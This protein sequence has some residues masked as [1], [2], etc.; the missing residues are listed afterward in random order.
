MG[1]MATVITEQ[2]CNGSLNTSFTPS[3]NYDNGDLLF[4]YAFRRSTTAP[5]VGAGWTSVT[6]ASSGASS[7]RLGVKSAT[8]SS[9]AS[10]TWTNASTLLFAAFRSV[11]P[12]NF[13]ILAEQTGTSTTAQAG[14]G[15]FPLA[16]SSMLV[17]FIAA[18]SAFVTA[19]G[20]GF[21][22][23]GEQA[24]I[25]DGTTIFCF[26][27]A[28]RWD[29]LGINPNNMPFTVAGAGSIEWRTATL[30]LYPSPYWDNAQSWRNGVGI[31]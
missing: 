9:E 18:K 14:G 15:T 12:R 1:L 11:G 22:S 17:V 19:D 20:T 23:A 30:E 3:G 4:I 25:P 2:A 13:N 16:Q 6:S 31:G 8:S 27:T 5:S 7:F 24:D 10:G 21:T 29:N 26:Y 28:D